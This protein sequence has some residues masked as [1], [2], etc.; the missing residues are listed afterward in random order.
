MTVDI[1][2]A[3]VARACETLGVH[4]ADGF[5]T[6]ARLLGFDVAGHPSPPIDEPVPVEPGADRP[7]KPPQTS[8]PEVVDVENAGQSLVAEPV[9]LEPVDEEPLVGALPPG[10]VLARSSAD[11]HGPPPPHPPLLSPR[12]AKGIVQYLM[13]RQIA[14]GEVDVTALVEAIASSRPPVALI[15]Q[16]QRTLRFGAQVLVDLSDSMRPFR[17]D[18]VHVTDIVRAVVG[19]AST[20]VRHFAG[21]PTRG[22]GTGPRWTWREYTPPAPGSRVL[23][24]TEF[25]IGGG[26][27][28]PGHIGEW[29]AFLD[30]LRNHGCRP[31]ALVPYPPARFPGRILARCPMLLWDRGVTVGRARTVAA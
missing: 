5:A 12:S 16:P 27:P 11:P 31:V 22:A 6:V 30:G 18:Q 19:P 8:T 9:L 23:L 17:R 20:D 13:S 7:S 28:R 21:V 4:S 10:A 1:W 24:L 3:D 15:R 25:G 29:L 26:R 2:W 14:D